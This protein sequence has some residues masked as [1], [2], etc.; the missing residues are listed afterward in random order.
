M[1]RQPLMAAYCVTEP[2]A[3]SDVANLKTK[4]V[5]CPDQQVWDLNGSKM[6]ITNAG[7]ADWFFVLAKTDDHDPSMSIPPSQKKEEEKGPEEKNKKKV[8]GASGG[9]GGFTGFIV[10]A[11]SPGITVGRKEWN[12]G[13]RASDTR[14]IVF[15]HVKVPADHVVG[16]PGQGFKLAMQ[17]FDV[18]RP[19]VAAAA[20]GLA[21]RCLHES[22]EYAKQRQTM[23]SILL[24]HQAIAFLL[25]DMYMQI[26]AARHLVWNAAKLLDLGLRNT[27]Q[28]SAAKCFAADMANVCASH[29]VQ[30]FGGNGYN[31]EYPVEKLLRDAKIFQIYEG[32]SQI[33]RMIMAKLLADMDFKNT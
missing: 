29:A 28:A 24:R 27:L 10:D 3:G 12:L 8:E 19:L 23:G 25:A 17:A 2:G 6:W 20:V 11:K 30:I 26:E 9:G 7:H 32:T 33:Q 22:M 1:T 15:E 18:T 5:W 14:G 4:A 31:S 13:Q 16:Q 21:R